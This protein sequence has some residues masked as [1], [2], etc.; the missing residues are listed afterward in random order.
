MSAEPAIVAP[1]E[2]ARY[3]PR[4]RL[5]GYAFGVMTALCWATSP[6]LI[7]K[8]L[9]GLP[10]PNWG[11]TVGMASAMV[12][13][14]TWLIIRPARLRRWGGAEGRAS[15][16]A[17]ILFLLIAGAISGFGS[18]ARTLAID[19]APVVIAI[20]L[21]QTASLFTVVLAPLL[22]GRHVEHVPPRLLFG[23][24]LVVVGS[25]LVILGLNR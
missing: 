7:K 6:I 3:A 14:A 25:A 15:F 16:R 8:G 22:L 23:A 11:I 17:P 10:S 24:S 5:V 20:P 13:V 18:L 21:V 1:A 19:M 9:K 12:V 4:D 2:P